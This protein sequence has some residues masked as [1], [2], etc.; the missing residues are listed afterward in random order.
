M[1]FLLALLS[2]RKQETACSLVTISKIRKSG[3][4]IFTFNTLFHAGQPRWIFRF[5]CGFVRF[6]GCLVIYPS[7]IVCIS[8]KCYSIQ[9]PTLRLS[10]NN[11][12]VW[13]KCAFSL[14]TFDKGLFT[15]AQEDIWRWTRYLTCNL[16]PVN[17]TLWPFIYRYG[18]SCYIIVQCT[19]FCIVREATHQRSITSRPSSFRL[20]PQG[21]PVDSLMASF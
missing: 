2:S 19:R 16:R 14:S 9:W 3:W 8:S 12:S 7:I 13:I 17:Y 20:V 21:G 1:K 15:K 5:L 18:I 10:A 11:G 4:K 6:D